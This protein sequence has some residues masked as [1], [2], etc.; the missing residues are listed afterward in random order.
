MV[1]CTKF[2]DRDVC[3]ILYFGLA[4]TFNVILRLCT[5]VITAVFASDKVSDVSKNDSDAYKRRNLTT[6]AIGSSALYPGPGLEV[7]AICLL[8]SKMDR[9]E[10]EA[11]ML[12]ETGSLMSSS[13]QMQALRDATV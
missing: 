2:G 8:S 12:T 9:L 11:N 10:R 3:V 1:R 4:A 5:Q 6:S 13:L 7:I